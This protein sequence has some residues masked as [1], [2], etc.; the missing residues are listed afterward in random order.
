MLEKHY[1]KFKV[2]DRAADFSGLAV[3]RRRK[4]AKEKTE[5]E[6]ARAMIKN[7]QKTINGLTKTIERM[8]IG[9]V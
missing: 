1:S 7:L 8:N 5:L 4:A 2:E 3:K 9:K 6:E